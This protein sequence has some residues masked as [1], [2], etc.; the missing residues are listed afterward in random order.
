MLLN[1]DYSVVVL[2]GIYF[3]KHNTH[4]LKVYSSWKFTENEHICVTSP[5][6]KTLAASH[7]TPPSSHYPHAVFFLKGV[8]VYVR[9]AYGYLG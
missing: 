6:S 4:R 1:F 5:I 7:Y 9:I 2:P 3:L 8:K